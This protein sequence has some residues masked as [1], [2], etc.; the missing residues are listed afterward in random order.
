[1][2]LVENPLGN[3]R[4]FG[5]SPSRLAVLAVLVLIVS[6]FAGCASQ[7]GTPANEPPGAKIAKNVS[8]GT[9]PQ[10]SYNKTQQAIAAAV[11][12]GNYASNVTYAYHSGNETVEIKVTVKGD[13]I[14]AASVTAQGK[15]APISA[16]IIGNFNDALPDLVVGKKITELNMPKNVAGS[17]LTNAAF[18]QYVAGLIAQP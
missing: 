1:V 14:T 12:D 9:D 16:K 13:V 18:Q 4:A 15:T 11:A 17:S 6:I 5:F 8:L 10:T 2:I 7:Q 3:G